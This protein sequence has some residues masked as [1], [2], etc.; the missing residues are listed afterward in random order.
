MSDFDVVN[1]TDG[2]FESH[3]ELLSSSE[4]E[5]TIAKVMADA[6]AD[7]NH[8]YT[9]G[10]APNHSRTVDRMLALRKVANPPE[11]NPETG[12]PYNDGV[13]P[14]MR[15]ICNEALEEQAERQNVV[16]EQM[17]D[18]MNYLV[19]EGGFSRDEI[20]K[21][22]KPYQA[23]A[24]KMQRLNAEGKHAEIV[25]IMKRELNEFRAPAETAQLFETFVQADELDSGLKETI[26]ESV[27]RWIHDARKNQMKG[28]Q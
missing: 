25:P 18:D 16:R 2:D 20:P 8:S 24:L 23:N 4:A 5:S 3:V 26:F 12:E 11:I 19:D 1:S 7:E 17:K 15:K 9:S 22:P 28:N 21:D 27:L 10:H 6:G 14:E 13:S